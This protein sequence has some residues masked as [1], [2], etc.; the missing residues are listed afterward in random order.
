MKSKRNYQR[1]RH[2]VGGK[3][4]KTLENSAAMDQQ[5]LPFKPSTGDTILVPRAVVGL[6]RSIGTMLK[7]LGLE[8]TVPSEPIAIEV[9]GHIFAKVL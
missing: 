5:T 4:N 1:Q 8:N 3:E 2:S 6:M 7:D 9:K